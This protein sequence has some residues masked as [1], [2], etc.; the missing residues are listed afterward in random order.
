MLLA[1]VGQDRPERGLIVFR[2]EEEVIGADDEA[3]LGEGG[4]GRIGGHA[5]EGASGQSLEGD[6][7]GGDDGDV[8]A[9]GVEG[10][11]DVHHPVSTT[12]QDDSHG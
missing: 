9:G 3:V 2:D 5:A 1:K 11:Q 6:R 4:G 7:V 10:L 12:H 8:G